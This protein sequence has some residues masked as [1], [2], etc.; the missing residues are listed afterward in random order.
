[1]E[2][3][4]GDSI[5][6]MHIRQQQLKDKDIFSTME[7]L[8]RV[9]VCSTVQY[10]YVFMYLWVHRFMDVSIERVYKLHLRIIQ[11]SEYPQI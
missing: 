3:E 4:K 1:V 6:Y 8:A 10:I 11:T 9:H 2:V 7:L 5:H